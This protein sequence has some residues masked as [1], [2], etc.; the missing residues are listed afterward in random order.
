MR[1]TV[2]LC[3]LKS[4]GR[5]LG[6]RQMSRIL[7]QYN[8]SHRAIPESDLLQWVIS[9]LCYQCLL[10]HGVPCPVRFFHIQVTVWLTMPNHA[11]GSLRLREEFIVVWPMLIDVEWNLHAFGILSTSTTSPWWC[12]LPHL[13]PLPAADCCNVAMHEDFHWTS[14][15]V[16]QK[17]AMI[18]PAAGNSP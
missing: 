10:F 12:C 1:L 16:D 15:S 3:E 14:F 13:M 5:A 8:I 11:N 7:K 4:R 2:L 6:G 9:C 18:L 17:N